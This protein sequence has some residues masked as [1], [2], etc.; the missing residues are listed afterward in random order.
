M[1]KFNVTHFNPLGMSCLL[2]SRYAVDNT[3]VDFDHELYMAKLDSD[4][5]EYTFTVL[6]PSKLDKAVV[7]KQRVSHLP[8]MGGTTHSHVIPVTSCTLI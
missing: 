4:N 1:L 3:V 2:T 6:P 8:A 5:S 7:G